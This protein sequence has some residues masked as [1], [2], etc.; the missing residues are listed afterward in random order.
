MK[1]LNVRTG[2]RFRDPSTRR[3]FVL[4]KKEGNMAEVNDG[5]RDYAWPLQANVDS[6]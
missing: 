2:Q 5:K 6:L 3:V 4:L 1:L